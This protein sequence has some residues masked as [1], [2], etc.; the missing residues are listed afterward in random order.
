MR[1]NAAVRWRGNEAAVNATDG[2][3]AFRKHHARDDMPCDR[4]DR[5]AHHGTCDP[6]CRCDRDSSSLNDSIA[7]SCWAGVTAAVDRIGLRAER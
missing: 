1:H 5:A 4:R 2:S 3:P 6:L 7:A